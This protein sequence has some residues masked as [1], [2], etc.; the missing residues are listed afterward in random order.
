MTFIRAPYIEKTGENVLVA[1]IVDGKIVGVEY[2][3]QIGIAFH[4]E[5]DSDLSV[6]KRFIALTAS[7]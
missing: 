2:K 6:H 1:A 3:N 5:L 4:P 7:P